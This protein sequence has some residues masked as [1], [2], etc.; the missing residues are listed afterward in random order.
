MLLGHFTA[1]REELGI[2]PKRM[3]LKRIERIK[4]RGRF[5]S[6]ETQF[7]IGRCTIFTW[8]GV[9]RNCQQL[10]FSHV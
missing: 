5:G 8:G 2:L 10:S 1:K 3:S 4:S 6:G 9:G 7:Q